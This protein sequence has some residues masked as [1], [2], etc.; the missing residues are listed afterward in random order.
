MDAAS[1]SAPLSG[2]STSEAIRFSVVNSKDTI[3]YYTIE[4]GQ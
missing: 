3:Q 4:T 2:A 1:R